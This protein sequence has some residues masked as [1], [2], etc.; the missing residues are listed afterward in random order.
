MLL[1]R[2]KLYLAWSRKCDNKPV[3]VT[4]SKEHDA[5][6]CTISNSKTNLGRL[7]Q[8]LSASRS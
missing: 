7:E 3:N 6:E 5:L 8:G 1:F 2:K 4:T